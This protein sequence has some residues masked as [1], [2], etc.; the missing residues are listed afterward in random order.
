MAYKGVI[1]DLDGTLLNTLQDLTDS[2]NAALTR[3]GLPLHSADEYKY[4]VG[5]GVEE[6]ARRVLPEVM[7]NG[8]AIAGLVADIRQEYSR[9]WADT[10]RPYEGIPE[11]LDAL[12]TRGIKMSVLSNKPEDS[13][14]ATV[15]RLLDRWQ[16]DFD[17][18]IGVSPSVPRKPDPTA[19]LN[20]AKQMGIPP[21]QMIYVGDTDTDMKTAVAAGM[22]PV[23][24]L[25]GYRTAEE[26]KANGARI[27]LRRPAELLTILD[28]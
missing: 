9:R 6:L 24:A 26:L 12:R 8:E 27:L 14:R 1:F 25:W 3:A 15:S 2:V 16:S 18:V 4:F 11:L 5:D 10:T 13:T 22:Y 17:M 19:A 7:R 28:S 23:G 21:Q 20:M